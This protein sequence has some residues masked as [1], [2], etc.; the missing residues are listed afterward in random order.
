ME[1]MDIIKQR[2]ESAHHKSRMK[3]LVGITAED[4]ACVE[5]QLAWM[6]NPRCD[7]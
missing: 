4:E 1:S 6:L 5:P 7:N 2:E 3:T